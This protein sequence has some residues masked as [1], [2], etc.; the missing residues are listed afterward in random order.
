[1][2]FWELDSDNQKWTAE[3]DQNLLERLEREYGEMR[4]WFRASRVPGIPQPV[5]L[6]GSIVKDITWTWNHQCLIR[7]RVLRL[8]RE[9]GFTGFGVHPVSAKWKR[10]RAK[11]GEA[12]P[13][14][15]PIWELTPFGW[16]GVASEESGMKW[17]S[18]DAATGRRLYS[19]Y[20]DP[21]KLVDEN[22]W[23]GSDFFILWPLPAHIY[24]S[25][26]VAQ[27]ILSEHLTGAKLTRTQDL[28]W[29]GG[30][31]DSCLPAWLRNYLPEPKARQIGEP[32]GSTR[33]ANQDISTDIRS[34]ICERV[35]V[36]ER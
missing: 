21:S 11:R 12:M 28:V 35:F 23:D 33:G 13:E 17:M 1:M 20:T 30:I 32:L 7:D 22:Q 34:G 10:L 9:Q 6:A 27:F 5:R 31:G 26:R 25:D 4:P 16:G 19:K 2:Q 14:I 24:V 8:F 29:P 3:N 36:Q 15:P 18:T